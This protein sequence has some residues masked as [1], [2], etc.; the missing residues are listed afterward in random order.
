MFSC[1]WFVPDVQRINTNTDHLT[2]ETPA[3][4]TSS[5]SRAFTYRALV[6]IHTIQFMMITIYVICPVITCKLHTS[7]SYT[8]VWAVHKP[9]FLLPSLSP[10]SSPLLSRILPFTNPSPLPP[11]HVHSLPPLLPHTP[12]SASPTNQHLRID[13]KLCQNTDHMYFI[14]QNHFHSF[15]PGRLNLLFASLLRTVL[16]TVDLSND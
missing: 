12:A 5:M 2:S 11:S 6:L 9:P 1:Q 10:S 7:I 13:L 16:G 15:V 4:S 8:T 14:W 3:S